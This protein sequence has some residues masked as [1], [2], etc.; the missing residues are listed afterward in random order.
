[1]LGRFLEI[2][3]HAPDVLN[4]LGFYESLGLSQATTGDIW[5]HPYAVVTD[6]HIA[7]GLHAYDFAS[8]ALTWIR[9][10]LT[11]YA[12]Q[13]EATGVALEFFKT[14]EEHFNELGFLDP[15]GQM[16][17]LLEARTFSAPSTPPPPPMI[18]FFQ[19][20]RYPVRRIGDA[21]T[22]WEP[23]GFVATEVVRDAPCRAALTSNGIDLCVF[24]SNQRP[25]ASLVF[26]AVDLDATHSALAER[27]LRPARIHDDVLG[28]PALA[29]SA[30]EG[31]PILV[32][33]EDFSRSFD[34][35]QTIIVEEAAE[36]LVEEISEATSQDST[37]GDR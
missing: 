32:V 15:D 14:G 27:D 34:E 5:R 29:L 20:Y 3:C 31:T 8:P 36:G 6:G 4:S 17:T 10:D 25:P 2:S 7:V 9:P 18:G 16:I 33:E 26:A 19:E 22:F 13:I 24:E 11:L 28:V 12:Q 35:T 37:D 30:P 1:M 23:K 21:I